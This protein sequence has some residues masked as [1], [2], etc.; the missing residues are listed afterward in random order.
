MKKYGI[1]LIVLTAAL[2]LAFTGCNGSSS[3]ILEDTKW[4]LDSYGDRNN[5]QEVIEG[6]E[7]TATFNSKDNQ[8]N[9]SA[10]CNRYFGDY[11]IKDG[12]SVGMLANTEMWCGEPEGRMDQETE[13]LKI[14]QAAEGYTI[15]NGTL[16]IDCGDNVLIYTASEVAN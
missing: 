7:I 2:I 6:T 3:D 15:N 4:I 10:G 8:V 14:L 5:P 9:G 12:L 1:L 16:T 11:E 13:Y